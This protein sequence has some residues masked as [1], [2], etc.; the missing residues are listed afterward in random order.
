MLLVREGGL[1]WEPLRSGCLFLQQSLASP[2]YALSHLHAPPLRERVGAHGSTCRPAGRFGV[3]GGR[4]LSHRFPFCLCEAELPAVRML[5]PLVPR[6]DTGRASARGWH[7]A[8]SLLCRPFWTWR[9]HRLGPS[10][11]P[12]VCTRWSQAL[13]QAQLLLAGRKD[14]GATLAQVLRKVPEARHHP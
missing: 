14:V 4:V 12:A 5:R 10:W 6:R 9:S 8:A 3:G 11:V 7:G 13:P 2:D 1:S